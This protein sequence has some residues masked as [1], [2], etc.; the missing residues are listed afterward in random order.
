LRFLVPDETLAITDLIC[1]EQRAVVSD[2]GDFMVLRRDQ[3]PSYQLA[4]VV[5]DAALDVSHVVRGNDLIS[6]TPCQVLLQ[7][8]LSLKTPS[9]A[10]VPLVL[11]PNGRRYAKRHDALS[12]RALRERGTDP[13]SI[14]QWVAGTLGMRQLGRVAPRDLLRDFKLEEIPRDPVQLDGPTLARLTDGGS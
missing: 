5:D 14:V 7:R 6:S 12:L 1:G 9:Y 8:T 4:V 10:H 11:D 3:V 13:R 2:G